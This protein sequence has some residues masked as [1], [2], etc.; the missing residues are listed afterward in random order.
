MSALQQTIRKEVSYSGIGLHTGNTTTVTF[1]PAPADHGYA[2]IRK[3]LPGEPR[4]EVDP[5]NVVI[6]D[7]ILQTAL[8]EGVERIYTVE[9]VL[10]ADRQRPAEHPPSLLRP[11]PHSIK[12][13]SPNRDGSELRSAA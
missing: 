4:V 10:S 11:L 9:H 8:G 13:H 2:F 5:D 1:K 12:E 3:D 6:E 7:A